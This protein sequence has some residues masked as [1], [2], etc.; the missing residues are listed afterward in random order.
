MGTAGEDV[1]DWTAD[2]V[3]WWPALCTGPRTRTAIPVAAGWVAAAA[4]T[5]ST[6]A[7]LKPDDWPEKRTGTGTRPLLQTADWKSR[8][9]RRLA[10]ATAPAGNDSRCH[11]RHSA[12]YRR[13]SPNGSWFL[14]DTPPMQSTPKNTPT[15]GGIRQRL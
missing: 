13:L 12:T 7:R 9:W 2:V 8:K 10:T 1:C 3:W 6:Q 15:K 4:D 11:G 5:P 14:N